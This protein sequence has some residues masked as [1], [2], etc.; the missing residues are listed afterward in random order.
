MAKA[1]PK[2]PPSRTHKL[3]SGETLEAAYGRLAP[4]RDNVCDEAEDLAAITIPSTF[5]PKEWR[6]GDR[7]HTPNTSV[8]AW[9]VN[10]LAS[11][12][13]FTAFPPGRPMMTYTILEHKL[14]GE[15]ADDEEVISKLD[16]ALSLLEQ[17]HRRRMEATTLRTTYTMAMKL[18]LI[19]GNW[20]WQH[21]ELDAPVV[22][23]MRHYV[24]K[25]DAFGR[26]LYAILRQEIEYYLLDEDIQD[27]VDRTREAKPPKGGRVD[28]MEDRVAVYTCCHVDGEHGSKKGWLVWQEVEG[29]LVPGSE[30]RDPYDAPSLSPEWLIPNYGQNWGTSYCAEY[31]GDLY[32]VD[33]F[34][35]DALDIAAIAAFSLILVKP[36]TRTR[37]KDV[38]EADNKSFLTGSAEDITVTRSD[39]GQDA[40][41]VEKQL[42][43]VERRLSFA[44]LLAIAAQ[45]DAERVTAEEIQFMA[46]QLDKAMGGTYSGLGQGPQR[47]V[48]KRFILLNEESD[49][50]L[51]EQP[52]EIVS[53]AVVTG[54]DALGRSLDYQNL[55][56]FAADIAETF[57][58]PG[59]AAINPAE[60]TR[61]L[62]AARG[63][64]PTG[65]VKDAAKMAAEQQATRA[66][67]LEDT[68]GAELAKHGT[69]AIAEG[70]KEAALGGQAPTI[71]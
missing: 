47:N 66:Q 36:G 44:F 64:R 21:E 61:R 30:G 19:T 14:T 26:P 70:V 59:L 45:R 20:L 25:R 17:A 69:K 42:A 23:T 51:P 33:N 34:G 48:V 28:P 65:L 58:E 35:G 15:E 10:N 52:E 6:P 50:D 11:M 67:G 3:H 31:R 24:V 60:F 71:N 29:E 8:G 54:I 53:L 40:A 46:E 62:A 2:A 4:E 43:S 57:G 9:C 38:E 41:I 5:P 55:K 18:A 12:L 56:G 22:H 32:A 16:L 27:I 49:A 68:A 39:K 13:M 7:L 63:I 1:K 37:K